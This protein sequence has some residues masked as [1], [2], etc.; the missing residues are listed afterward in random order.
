MANLTGKRFGDLEVLA[1]AGRSERGALL[2]KCLCHR[3]GSIAI[4]EGQRMT[5]KKSPKRDCGCSYREKRANLTGQTIGVLD[6]LE[7]VRTSQNGDRI[8][9]CRCKL[10]G[11][12]KELP[13]STIRLKLQ[14]CGCQRYNPERMTDMSK[15]GVEA[16]IIDGVN[17][18]SATRKEANKNSRTG[19]R[20]VSRLKNGL[21]RAH[22]QVKGERWVRDGFLSIES[23]KTARDKKQAELLKKYDVHIEEPPD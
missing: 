9:L 14:S 19:V 21:F 20:G 6:V 1:P 13:A 22:C 8:Y 18:P 16:T 3:C 23:A 5:A 11:H 10:C 12:E 7:Y 2:W 4:V 15:L 17:I